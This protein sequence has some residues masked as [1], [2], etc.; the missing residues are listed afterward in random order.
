MDR[1]HAECAV[2]QALADRALVVAGRL[3]DRQAARLPAANLLSAINLYCSLLTQTLHVDTTVLY[4]YTPRRAR[5]SRPV[6]AV[7]GV[8]SHGDRRLQRNRKRAGQ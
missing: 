8:R 3:A 7:A 6:R 2:A 5:G 1:G 4:E